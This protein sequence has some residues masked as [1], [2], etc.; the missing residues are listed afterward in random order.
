MLRFLNRHRVEA[1]LF[2]MFWASFACVV[3]VL[4]GWNVNT[5]FALTCAMVD[6]GTFSIDAYHTDP[7]FE[8]DDKAFYNGRF[9]CD[10][11]PALSML[12][13]PFYALS[14]PILAASD[15]RIKV[16]Y[17]RQWSMAWTVCLLGAL[18]AVLFYRMTILFGASG[19]ESLALT[20]FLIYG[21]N[22]GGYTSLF[23]PYLPAAC[24]IVAAYTLVLSARRR[25]GAFGAGRAAAV[26]FLCSMAGFFEFTF[27]LAGLAT[28]AVAAWEMRPRRR[29]VW[30]ILAACLPAAALFAYNYWVF[31]RFALAYQFEAR[32]DFREGMSQGFMGI[33]RFKPA[34][35]Y[36]ITIHPYKGLF[37]YSPILFCFFLGSL[38]TK[39]LSG[40]RRIDLAAAWAV[41]IGYLAFN[42]SYYLWWG[43]WSMGARHLIPMLPFLFMPILAA[44]RRHPRM[45]SIVF[46]AGCVS[47]LLNL[48]PILVDPQMAPKIADAALYWPDIRYNLTSSWLTEIIP[49]FY[50]G[51]DLAVVLPLA[52]LPGAWPLAPWIV[53]WTAAL[54]KAS[55]W[56]R[57]D[58]P[59][60]AQANPFAISAA[61]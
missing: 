49:G 38:W 31:D 48:P 56:A 60:E 17:A 43:G 8:T 1:L 18:A 52:G 40:A 61:N 39:R 33:N 59:G 35:L 47:V 28:M 12:A 21:T 36:F 5:R 3:H 20:M 9:Y 25:G 2:L 55:R 44:M 34:V 4:P 54:W 6:R 11:S 50:S 22:L 13:A 58:D 53:L 51:R 37:F 14:K 46:F 29:A 26:G 24:C 45:R 42:A 10:K 41:L 23:Y 57:E 27:G 30:M 16:L 7:L 32:E 15:V 19:Q